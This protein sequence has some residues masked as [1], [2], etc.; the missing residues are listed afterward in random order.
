VLNSP[1]GA[2]AILGQARSLAV[3]GRQPE[4]GEAYS[5]FLSLWKDADPG[6]PMLQHAR[7]EAARLK[8]GS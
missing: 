4:A 1:L 8:S 6:I 2:M 7:A 5:R 3:A